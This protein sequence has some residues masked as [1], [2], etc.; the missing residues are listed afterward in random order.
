MSVRI[1]GLGLW[2]LRLGS[3]GIRVEGFQALQGGCRL[4]GL[5]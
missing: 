3:K 1:Q 2:G 4:S 5:D